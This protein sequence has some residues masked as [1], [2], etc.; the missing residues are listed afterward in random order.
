MKSQKHVRK[1]SSVWLASPSLNWTKLFTVRT[2]YLCLVYGEHTRSSNHFR[3][4]LSKMI[5]FSLKYLVFIEIH[6]VSNDFKHVF[7]DLK[8]CTAAK[9]TKGL[10]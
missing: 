3:T 1:T 2:V 9:E 4:S 6:K 8:T 7:N 5:R 10:R